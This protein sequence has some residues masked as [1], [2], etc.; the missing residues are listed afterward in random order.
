MTDEARDTATDRVVKKT[1][2]WAISVGLHTLAVL[3]LT[4]LFVTGAPAD[5]L[6]VS[7]VTHSHPPKETVEFRDPIVRT[8]AIKTS[9]PTDDPQITDKTDPT[10]EDPTDFDTPT[11][12]GDINANAD[13]P[14]KS[15][16]SNGSIGVGA[17]AGHKRGTG[18]GGRE[19]RRKKGDMGNRPEGDRATMSALLWLARHQGP[20]GGWGV[21][22][23]AGACKTSRCSTP[24]SAS[25]DFDI[26]VSG[27]SLLAF[28]GAGYS[29]LSKDVHEGIRFGEVV[30]RG[31]RHLLRQQDAE[32]FLGPRT[33]HKEMY[34]HTIA[35]L[36]LCEAYG[37][38]GSSLFKDEARRAV[39]YL[40]QAQNPGRGWRYSSRSGDNDTSVTG[41][42]VMVLKSAEL[43]GISFPRT[44]YDGARAWLD[45]TTEE[46]YG[47]AGYTHKGTGKVYCPHNA[48]FEHH[49]ALT[50]IAV[51]SRIFIDKKADAR[52]RNGA[53]L[54]GRDVPS[55]E[56]AKV[57]Y[58]AWY[59]AALALFQFDGPDGALWNKWSKG[60]VQALVKSQSSMGCEAGSWDPADRWGCEG[61]RVYA[62]AINAL[63][64]EV[65]YRFE[66]VLGG[67]RK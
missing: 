11:T 34:N 6:T 10:H 52:V 20:D 3:V 66:N 23:H 24:E 19:F 36:A 15:P 44:A 43:S 30:G 35:A 7:S 46:A 58:Y 27:L 56:P 38:T 50:S 28:L 12:V 33:G 29:H 40:V 57:D 39:D 1:P 14:F 67:K 42:A 9:T 63:T 47:R 48:T 25:A 53:E 2:W 8:T 49:E 18:I 37:L 31:L 41:W 32:G 17:R 22:S 16:S 45:E 51:M 61:G 60:M 26:G 55:L 13:S 65:Y 21:Q 59:Y 64:L 5:T 62:T 54:V 4:F